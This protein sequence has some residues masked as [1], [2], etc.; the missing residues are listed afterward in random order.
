MYLR[1]ISNCVYDCFP[2]LPLPRSNSPTFA[3]ILLHVRAHAHIYTH[4]YMRIFTRRTV[5]AQCSIDSVRVINVR[6]RARSKVLRLAAASTEGGKRQTD[7]DPIPRYRATTFSQIA[8]PPTPGLRPNDNKS[9]GQ[10]DAF[11]SRSRTRRLAIV[12]PSATRD[13]RLQTP[14]RSSA[15]CLS[16][17]SS[18][19][20][21]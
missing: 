12:C 3:K 6:A 13:D 7:V 1:K 10:A 8:T 18:L 19:R 9:T 4:V 21:L 15:T 14:S 2:V 16:R 17:I 5:N 11:A 20:R